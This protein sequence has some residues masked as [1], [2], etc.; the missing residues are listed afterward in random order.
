LLA[1][2]V[3]IEDAVALFPELEARLRVPA[4]MLSGGEQQ[5][6]ALA[7]AIARRPRVLLID[8]LSF[9]LAP[10][11]C[12]R[13]FEGLKL[14]AEVSGLAVLLVEQH[15]HYAEAVCDRVL[16]M[17]EGCIKLETTARGLSDREDEIGRL[18]LS[19]VTDSASDLT[20]L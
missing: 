20:D 2:G 16:V 12:E 4:G 5:M 1:G 17:N 13:L 11:V 8:E 7:R 9:G 14:V 6:L 10:V 18:Y 15:L 3:S 19:E